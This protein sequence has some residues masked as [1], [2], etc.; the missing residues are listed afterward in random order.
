M[1]MSAMARRKRTRAARSSVE[2]RVGLWRSCNPGE[3]TGG[4]ECLSAGGA[5]GK[6][7]PGKYHQ[8]Q[9]S[10]RSRRAGAPHE[11]V[12]RPVWI[13]IEDRPAAR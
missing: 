1:T 12:R 11:V 10:Q 7:L 6:M 3:E 13:S 9:G 2:K 4:I 5:V 8:S